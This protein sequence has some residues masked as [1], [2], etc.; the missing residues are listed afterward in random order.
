MLPTDGLD[1]SVVNVVLIIIL[2]LYCSVSVYWYLLIGC[3]GYA[4]VALFVRSATVNTF[5]AIQ[6]DRDR[7]FI[8][9]Q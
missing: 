7:R 2:L 6:S 4:D 8:Y 9:F 1:D 3:V 5:H